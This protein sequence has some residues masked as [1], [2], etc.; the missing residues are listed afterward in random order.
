MTISDLQALPCVALAKR[1]RIPELS[2]VYAVFSENELLYVGAAQNLQLRWQTHD[3]IT[4]LRTFPGI[5]IH[6]KVC[7]FVEADVLERL[8][9]INLQ[10]RLNVIRYKNRPVRV[11][12]P[13]LKRVKADFVVLQVISH[14][15]PDRAAAEA[16]LAAQPKGS[17]DPANCMILGFPVG[18]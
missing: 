15:H 18:S 14:S 6:W 10:P 13:R 17:V 3:R 8:L 2:G 9:I 4:Q 1:S 16:W 11:R 5:K 12:Q 7:D